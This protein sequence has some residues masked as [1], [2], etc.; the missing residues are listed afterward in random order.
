MYY[1][2]P[3]TLAYAFILSVG[4]N[5]AF[6][7]VPYINMPEKNQTVFIGFY[8]TMANLGALIGVTIGRQL[9]EGL[10]AVNFQF[11]GLTFVDKQVLVLIVGV[12]MALTAV[13]VYFLRRGVN[14]EA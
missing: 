6:T 5:L 11:L 2:Y 9:V 3:L 12:V 14:E 4:I 13:I 7:N 1:L 8:S 10:H